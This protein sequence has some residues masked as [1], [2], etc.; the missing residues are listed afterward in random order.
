MPATSRA[1]LG[2]GRPTRSLSSH[3]TAGRAAIVTSI[4]SASARQRRA[5]MTTPIAPAPRTTGVEPSRETQSA[6][7]STR[8]VRNATLASVMGRSHTNRAP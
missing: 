6:S 4:T 7:R 2:R 3:S 8:G 5:A 1:P